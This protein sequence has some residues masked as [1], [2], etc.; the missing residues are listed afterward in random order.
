MDQNL[1]NHESDRMHILQMVADGKVSANE[2][3]NLLDAMNANPKGKNASQTN[4]MAG[5][6]KT[7]AHWFRVR[8][9]DVQTGRSKAV[10]NIPLTLAEW[11]LRIGAKYAPE[12]GDVDLSELSQMLHDRNLEGKIIDVVDEEDGDHVEIFIE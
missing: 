5:D 9:T 1:S 10:V 6:G 4:R 11:G 12:V 3:V 2:G 7:E 8:V